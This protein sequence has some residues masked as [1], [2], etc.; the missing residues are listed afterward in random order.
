MVDQPFIRAPNSP[1]HLAK[2]MAPK[3][4]FTDWRDTE[5]GARGSKGGLVS[6]KA[7]G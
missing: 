5:H 1:A 6:A 7:L 4:T 3:A 2:V